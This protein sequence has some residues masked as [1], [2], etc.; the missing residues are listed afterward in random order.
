MHPVLEYGGIQNGRLNPPLIQ[1]NA[2]ILLFS[3]FEIRCEYPKI[4]EHK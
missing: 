3:I 1:A 2:L 4:K